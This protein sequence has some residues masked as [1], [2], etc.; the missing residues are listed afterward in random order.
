MFLTKCLTASTYISLYF[1]ICMYIK[2][3]RT[4]QLSL[5]MLYNQF[6]CFMSSYLLVN[7][8]DLLFNF[9]ILHDSEY[10]RKFDR[11]TRY[12]IRFLHLLWDITSVTIRLSILYIIYPLYMID[13][14]KNI[15]SYSTTILMIYL[16]STLISLFL[17][18]AVVFFNFISFVCKKSFKINDM[19]ILL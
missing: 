5:I 11:R 4:Q 3:S 7:L 13:P 12:I 18:I 15:H 16:I 9:Y 6:D 17:I 1:G 14:E 10:K 19:I 2:F 8:I